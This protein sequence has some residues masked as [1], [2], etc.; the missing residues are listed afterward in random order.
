MIN[1]K[2]ILSLVLV[3]VLCFSTIVVSSLSVNGDTNGALAFEFRKKD[4]DANATNNAPLLVTCNNDGSMRMQTDRIKQQYQMIFKVSDA[5]QQTLADAIEDTCENYDGAL[6]MRV[7]VNDAL[8]AYGGKCSPKV[9]VQLLGEPKNGVI[10]WTNII[11]D[12]GG[13]KQAPEQTSFYSFD[14]SKY[15]DE[16]YNNDIKYVYVRVECYDW[17]C[18]SG[19][20]TMPDVTFYPIYVDTG[21]PSESI[22]RS[23]AKPDPNQKTFF[24]F[25][26]KSRND[27]DY[28]PATLSYSSDCVNWKSAG[29]ATEADYGYLRMLQPNAVQ[30][31]QVSY[32]YNG[33]EDEAKNALNIAKTE[34]NS[35]KVKFRLSLDKC[36]DDYGNNTIAEVSYMMTFTK[37]IESK[38]PESISGAC[39]QYPGTTRTYY[40][41]V[42]GISH[43]SQLDSI[44]FRVQNYWYYKKDGT[45]FDYDASVRAEG[46]TP[47]EQDAIK[48]G[49]KMCRIKPTVVVSPLTVVPVEEASATNTDYNLVLNSFNKNG[50]VVPSDPAKLAEGDPNIADIFQP[51]DSSSSTTTTTNSVSTTTTA[52]VV[53]SPTNPRPSTVTVPTTAINNGGNS[54]NTVIGMNKALKPVIKLTAKKKAITLKLTK[55]VNGAQGYQ[56]KY[57]TNKKLKKA[58]T[59]NLKA[60]KKSLTIKKL[61]SKK[62]YYFRVRAYTTVNGS[63]VYGTWSKTYNKKVK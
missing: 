47:N 40:I 2:K 21:A 27:Y 24:K 26:N 42:T 51:D 25:T 38:A 57:S 46:G 7:D 19:K 23:T 60:N 28:G 20:G 59:K 48:L 12:T 33:I 49:Y 34:G 39:W 61:K 62:K 9:Q 44:V 37:G 10:D 15:I 35:G 31:M 3:I 13:A 36:V 55:K 17:G 11:A 54:N 56:I 30:Q 6:T 1:N 53:T 43:Y 41:D 63:K 45:L 4:Y 50:G 32:N 22:S 18:G 29:R 14:L 52:P 8:T 58:K 5:A 16:E